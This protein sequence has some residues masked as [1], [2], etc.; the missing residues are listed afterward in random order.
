VLNAGH[1]CSKDNFAATLSKYIKEAQEA[2]EQSEAKS[3]KV[4]KKFM[5]HTDLKEM[6]KSIKM[7]PQESTS[8]RARR[9]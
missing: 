7:S 4:E 3:K 6:L 8:K 9:S 2:A 5:E 1:S